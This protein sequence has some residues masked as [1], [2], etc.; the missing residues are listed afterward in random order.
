MILSEKKKAIRS[1]GDVATIMRSILAA[2]GEIDS[3]KEHFWV[4]GV[5]T[6][7]VIQY[8]ELTALG[9]LNQ[10]VVGPREVFR[11]AVHKAV[12]N[13][14]IAHNHPSGD[15]E[16]SKED[17]VITQRLVSAGEILGIKIL[18]HIIIGDPEFY[19]FKAMNLLL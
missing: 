11:L 1:P 8:L 5:N 2:E 14:L 18:D 16:P 9:T 4:I 3:M 15:P 7:N 13:I 12:S 17:T 19:S 6:K 10:A